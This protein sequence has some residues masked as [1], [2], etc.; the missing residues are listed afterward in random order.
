L[1]GTRWG[2][3]D[4]LL[5]DLPP[6]AE[7][8]LQLA[9]MLG[10]R[11]S[12]VLVTTPSALAGRVVSRSLAALRAAGSRVLGYVDNM[13]GYACAG[14]GSVQP[15]FPDEGEP[16]PLPLLGRVPFDPGLAALCARGWPAGE[17]ESLPAVVACA[18][19]AAA[20]REA[21]AEATVAQTANPYQRPSEAPR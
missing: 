8:T 19:V 16:L 4:A 2:E 20:L 1:A 5:L 7:R 17:G 18:A 3:L 13:A 14:C 15:L 9:Q 21:L 6:G 11:A 10:A 12:F